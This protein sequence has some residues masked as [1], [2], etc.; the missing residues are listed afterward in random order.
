[1]AT[2]TTTNIDPAVV[3]FYNGILQRKLPYLIHDMF[4]DSKPSPTGESDQIKFRNYAALSKATT[5][6][7][8]ARVPTGSLAS[9]SEV[10]FTLDQYGDYLKYS[11]KVSLI[12]QDPVISVL[13][14]MG[15]EQAQ[16]TIDELRRNAYIAGTSVRRAGGVSARSGIVTEITNNDLAFV[17][18]A[19]LSNRCRYT[20]KMVNPQNGYA[21]SPTRASFPVICHTDC[22]ASVENLTGFQ[23]VEKYAGQTAVHPTEIGQ[24]GNFR[25]YCTSEAKIWADGGGS[26]VAASLKY[27]TGTANCDVYPYLIFSE[28]AVAKSDLEG[29]ALQSIVKSKDSGGPENPLNQYGTVGWVAWT[30]QGILDD[31]RLYR[32]EAGVGILS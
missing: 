6:I 9:Y 14:E 20:K 18:R 8:E 13:T 10:T 21:T 2:N 24:V 1:M 23:S 31:T 28:H 11:D 17:E 5:P 27:T 30:T 26:A 29:H 32:I 22:K 4:A 3:P 16:E 15:G 12:N 25:F 19:M 7:S